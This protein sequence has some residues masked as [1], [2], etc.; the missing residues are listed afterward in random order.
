MDM[1]FPPWHWSER[2]ARVQASLLGSFF[3]PRKK[4]RSDERAS[5]LGRRSG[6]DLAL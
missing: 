5:F 4:V 1:N 6:G 2:P 3:Y